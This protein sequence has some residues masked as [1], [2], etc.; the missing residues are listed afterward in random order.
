MSLKVDIEK[1]YGRFHLRVK[2]E[3]DWESI[4]LLGASGC[5]KSLTLKCIAGI[6]KPDRGKIILDDRVLYDSEQ[7][8]NLPA[9]KRR[10]GYVFQNFALFPNMT[11]EENIAA[12][13]HH[14]KDLQ[15]EERV[16]EL[17]EMFQLQDTK[18]KLPR[19]LSGGQQQRVALARILA[20]EPEVILL[21]EPFSALDSHLKWQLELEMKSLL[22]YFGGTIVWVS[23][24]LGE[25]YR[26]CSRICI[27]DEGRSLPTST[28]D[29]LMKYPHTVP[30][31]RLLGFQNFVDLRPTD[32]PYEQLLPDLMLY[33][34]SER[35][36]KP[37]YSKIGIRSDAIHIAK[38]D[39][40]RFRCKVEQVTEDIHS[41]WLML[42][43]ESAFHGAPLLRMEL[44]KEQWTRQKFLTVSIA[45]KDIILLHS[46]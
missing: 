34:K 25:I 20:S 2:F 15:R 5:G 35:P 29:A 9:Q 7:R 30:A 23:H 41:V 42:R 45:P 32:D 4:G 37:G 28:Y 39:V 1:C 17:M 21:D 3:A 16:E 38:N 11:A 6:E 19:E 26:N 33:V 18:G 36:W 44:P 14:L 43:P 10:V 22:K 40:N 27:I 46:Y 13:A 12:G 24:D 8:V 31:A